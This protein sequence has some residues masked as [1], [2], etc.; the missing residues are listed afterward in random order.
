MGSS[1]NKWGYTHCPICN[2]DAP[3]KRLEAYSDLPKPAHT[4]ATFKAL[5]GTEECLAAASNFATGH[6]G[7]SGLTI[8]G[9]NGNGKSHLLEAIGWAMLNQGSAV[10]YVFV[11]ALLQRLR[12]TYDHKSQ[13]S[14]AD[15]WAVYERAEVLLLDD[16]GEH[17]TPTPWAKGQMEYLIERRY[18]NER[19][20]VLTTN[21]TKEQ[22]IEAWSHRLEDRVFD[23]G[24]GAVRVVYNLAPSYR[25]GK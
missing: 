15:V 17:P 1:R 22:M 20:W 10:K 13:E 16:L 24:T 8:V 4:F 7:Y 23:E 3:K 18:R 25:S 11:P 12:N 14:F 2:A 5:P 19:P 21:L 9:T 6:P